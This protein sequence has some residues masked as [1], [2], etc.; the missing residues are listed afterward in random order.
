MENSKIIQIF[1]YELKQAQLNK[2][3]FC[4][5][6]G[7]NLGTYKNAIRINTKIVPRWVYAFLLGR[8]YVIGISGNLYKQ[9]ANAIK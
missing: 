8:G 2:N 5:M 1:N 4:E 7:M 9:D 3:S 6:L